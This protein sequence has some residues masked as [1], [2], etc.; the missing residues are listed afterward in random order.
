MT[1]DK[2]YR[3]KTLAQFFGNDTAKNQ[4][5]NIQTDLPSVILLC[6]TTGCGKTTLAR[7]ITKRLNYDPGEFN[8]SDA[9]GINEARAIIRIIQS[10]S[11][12]KSGKAII[13]N[14]MQGA[15]KYFM[16]A[17]L[18]VLEEPPKNVIFIIC[19]T[20]PQ[21]LLPAIRSRCT[22][23]RVDPLGR[24]DSVKLINRIAQ[25]EN[26]KIDQYIQPI[27]ESS[28]G[29]P[30][31]INVILSSI[32]KLKSERDILSTIE[33]YGYIDEVPSEDVILFC[34]NILKKAQFKT[35]METINNSSAQPETIKRVVCSY[36]SKILLNGKM[37]K[38]AALILDVF[39]N[40]NTVQGMPAIVNAVSMLYFQN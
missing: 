39:L 36:M 5:K 38:N 12:F 27:I 16:N 17:L 21:A 20:E 28:D 32:A 4:I 1:F 7:I 24:D 25:K 23:I 34:R 13:L 18:E 6:G 35:V 26:L 30:R 19:T 8:I 29:I 37:D 2:K 40:C 22:V 31:K 11:L 15:N 33:S 10:G 14:E 3:P 9:R